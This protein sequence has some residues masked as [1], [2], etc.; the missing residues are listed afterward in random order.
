VELIDRFLSS[1]RYLETRPHRQYE[2]EI[3]NENPSFLRWKAKI[4]LQNN[5]CLSVS[6]VA[7]FDEDKITER[8]FAYDLRDRETGKMIWRID[9]HSRRQSVSS[10]CHVHTN[11]DNEEER[12]DEYFTDSQGTDFPYVMRCVRKHFEQEPQDWEVNH[13]DE[14]E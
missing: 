9:N 5:L 11:P 12:N 6:E 13:D 2:I 3:P 8:V 10:P 4:P 14:T 7:I 1:F